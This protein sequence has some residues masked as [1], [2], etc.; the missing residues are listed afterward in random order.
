VSEQGYLETKFFETEQMEMVT[1]KP[2]KHADE[3]EMST[4]RNLGTSFW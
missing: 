1:L 3:T 4:L 2:K